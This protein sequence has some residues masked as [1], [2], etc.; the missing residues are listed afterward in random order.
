MTNITLNHEDK[1][2]TLTRKFAKLS[3]NPFSREGKQLTKVKKDY[4][5]YEIVVREIKINTDKDTYEGLTYE[6]MRDYIRRYSND[7]TYDLN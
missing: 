5:D 7:V 2:I 3:S 4:P 6:Y 1:T